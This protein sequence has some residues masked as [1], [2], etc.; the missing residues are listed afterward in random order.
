VQLLVQQALEKIDHVRA[1][2]GTAL[3]RVLYGPAGAGVAD[4]AELQQLVPRCGVAAGA[5]QVGI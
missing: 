3:R 2:A 4:L 1:T 5:M